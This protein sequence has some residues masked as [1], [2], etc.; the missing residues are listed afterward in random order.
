MRN[1]RV[2]LLDP[3][4]RRSKMVDLPVMNSP[5]ADAE[6]GLDH[7]AL[8]NLLQLP[9]ASNSY[10][11]HIK[12]R[13]VDLQAPGYIAMVWSFDEVLRVP[14]CVIVPH[15]TS[16]EAVVAGPVLVVKMQVL[17]DSTVCARVFPCTAR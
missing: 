10:R 5:P 7:D 9:V 11:Q 15:N 4:K 12:I 6:L 16:M 13:P 2:L 1:V 17:L 8:E 14:G 3:F